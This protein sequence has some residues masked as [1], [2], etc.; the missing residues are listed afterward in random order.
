MEISTSARHLHVRTAGR[1]WTHRRIRLWYQSVPICAIVLLDGKALSA[2]STVLLV[3]LR[4]VKMEAHVMRR[5]ERP[6][7]RVFLVSLAQH[8]GLMLMSVS[9][10][11]AKTVVCA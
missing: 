9:A 1:V 5:L 7:V 6:I 10:H 2:T 8:V 4:H 11:R 3:H